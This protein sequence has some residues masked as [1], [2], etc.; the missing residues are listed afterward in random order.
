MGSRLAV[1]RI[2]GGTSA[3]RDEFPWQM[4]VQRTDGAFCGGVLIDNKHVLTAA[5]CLDFKD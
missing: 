3:V 4:A 1:S 2:I 5:H